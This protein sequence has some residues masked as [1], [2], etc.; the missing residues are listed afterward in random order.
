[1]GVDL[2]LR[3]R[4]VEYEEFV[5]VSAEQKIFVSGA[6]LMGFETDGAGVAAKQSSFLPH[7]A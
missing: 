6:A 5:D 2:G 4:V 3:Q 1:V 7:V